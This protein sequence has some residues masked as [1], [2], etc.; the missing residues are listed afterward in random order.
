MILS[1]ALYQ[2]YITLQYM[3][4]I[5]YIRNIF[6]YIIRTLDLNCK[7]IHKQQNIMH[8]EILIWPTKKL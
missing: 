6:I 3:N 7:I 5:L 4:L 2:E 8:C 1:N